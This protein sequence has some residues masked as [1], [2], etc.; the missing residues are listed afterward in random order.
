MG[1]ESACGGLRFEAPRLNSLRSS[2]TKNL[3]GQAR[4]KANGLPISESSL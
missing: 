3:T 2:S 1:K 4:Q